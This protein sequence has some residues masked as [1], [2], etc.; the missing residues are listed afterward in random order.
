M[1]EKVQNRRKGS[2]EV[3][4][5]VVVEEKSK[6]IMFGIA[7]TNLEAIE[8]GEKVGILEDKG[9]EWLTEKGLVSKLF[10]LLQKI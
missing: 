4:P 2:I 6:P 7:T 5:K 8:K 1:A 3:E 9:D 10:L